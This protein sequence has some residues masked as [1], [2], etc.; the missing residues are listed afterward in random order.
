[1]CEAKP[2]SLVFDR[3]LFKR[4]RLTNTPACPTATTVASSRNPSI[5][6]QA[7]TFTSKVTSGVGT[8]TGSVT[9]KDGATTIGT[10]ALSAGTATF[11]T[12]ALS[13]GTHSIKAIY[14]GTANLATSTSSSVAQTVKKATT[15]TALASSVNPSSFGQKITFTAKVTPQFGGT[16]TG[17]VV[18]K[19]GTT[20][21]GAGAISGGQATLSVSLLHPGN[22]SITATYAG[23][24]SLVGSTSRA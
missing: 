13:G 4:K 6:G 10:G 9:F 2:I 24:G 16:A 18:F 20:T 15:K 21:V 3:C 14:N 19:D 8:P 7:V 11:T 1:L 22:H 5:F 17:N 12:S 23:N